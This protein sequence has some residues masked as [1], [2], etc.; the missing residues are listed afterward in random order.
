[1]KKGS[2]RFWY[3]GM[4]RT[5]EQDP[6][7]R[8]EIVSVAE[9]PESK[10]LSVLD[11]RFFQWAGPFNTKVAAKFQCDNPTATIATCEFMTRSERKGPRLKARI[12]NE[13]GRLCSKCGHRHA[14]ASPCKTSRKFPG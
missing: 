13:W 5:T 8:K 12:V 14:D 11:K 9:D 10:W 7:P 2:R 4:T 3:V 1:M 6:T